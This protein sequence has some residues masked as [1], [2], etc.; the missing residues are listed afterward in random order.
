MTRTAARETFLAELGATACEGGVNYWAYV[1]NYAWFLPYL[2]DSST[3]EPSPSGGGAFEATLSDKFEN[4]FKPTKI[5]INTVA[6][7]INRIMNAN[8]EELKSKY[9]LSSEF[10]TKLRK[11]SNT[12][13]DIDSWIDAGVADIVIQIG[14]FDEVIY[15]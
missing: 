15:A 14:M 6:T 1:D 11:A 10:R 4:D 9:G 7:G 3:C 8:L 12:N 2:S 13:D 5:N